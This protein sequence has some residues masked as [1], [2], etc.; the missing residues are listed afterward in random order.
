MRHISCFYRQL[1]HRDSAGRN[2][3]VEAD[4]AIGYA[5]GIFPADAD[6]LVH[7]Q[8]ESMEPRIPN[9]SYVAVKY[10]EEIPNPGEYIVCLLEGGEMVCKQYIQYI[11]DGESVAL[12][13]SLNRNYEDIVLTPE[14]DVVIQGKVL[15]SRKE[16][17]CFQVE[18]YL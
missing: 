18:E 5:E 1:I 15:V 11:K 8:G 9:D 10:T 7:I 17:A 4:A 3:I 12:L 14:S 16:P 2:T 6:C 13:K